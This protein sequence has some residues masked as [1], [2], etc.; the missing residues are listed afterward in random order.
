MQSKKILTTV[1]A[2][3]AMA[4]AAPRSAA[5]HSIVALQNTGLQDIAPEARGRSIIAF[6][7]V[8]T[9]E[10]DLLIYGPIGDY[11]WDEGVTAASIV[12]QLSQI[13]AQRINVRIN[14]DGG[15]V[16]DGLAIYNALRNHP[17]TVTVII[18]GFAASIARLIAQA[19]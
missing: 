18:D 5:P 6:D 16:M 11:F 7:N 4:A 9:S 1:A 3:T 12:E 14:S 19:G 17:A 10:V 2:A 8:S 13:Q 15:V